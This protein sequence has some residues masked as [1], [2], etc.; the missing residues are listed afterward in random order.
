MTAGTC[1]SLT[2]LEVEE[3]VPDGVDGVARDDLALVLGAV[4]RDADHLDL[5]DRAAVVRALAHVLPR[6]Q[7]RGGRE[8]LCT[9]MRDVTL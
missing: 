1:T 2:H 6:D 4:G 7:L 5:D 3:L 9:L 8:L